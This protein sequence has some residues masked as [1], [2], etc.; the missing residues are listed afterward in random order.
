MVAA[1]NVDGLAFLGPFNDLVAIGADGNDLAAFLARAVRPLGLAV[2]P[3]APELWGRDAA[4]RSDQA[5][6]ADAGIP[7]ILT[8]EGFDQPGL[9]FAEAVA[10]AQRWMGT[11]YHQPSD[12]LAQPLD[13]AAARDHCQAILALVEELAD[14][15]AE[16]AWTSGATEAYQRALARSRDAL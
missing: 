12:D 8:S 3:P 16:P 4:L 9:S 14:S 10:R 5:A 11:T 7:A 2:T 15:A 6:F 1:V 13:L